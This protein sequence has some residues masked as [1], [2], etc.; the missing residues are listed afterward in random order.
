LLCDQFARGQIDDT[1]NLISF[2]TVKPDEWRTHEGFSAE[3]EEANEKLFEPET[4]ESESEQALSFWL[5]KHQPCLFGRIAAKFGV[6]SYCML[7]EADLKQPDE[8]IKEKIQAARLAWTQ[9]GFEGKKSAFIILAISPR[10]ASALPGPEMRELARRLC[11]LYLETDIEM[12]KVHLEQIYLQK[13]GARL[14]NMEM[15]CGG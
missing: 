3:V 5:Q 11:Y 15:A 2:F 7:S 9:N 12:D 1:F 13:P 8:F 14:T 4:S 6:I 10:I